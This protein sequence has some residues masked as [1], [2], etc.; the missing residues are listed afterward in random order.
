MLGAS[1]G[2]VFVPCAGPGAGAISVVAATN[3]VGL[4]A[5]LLTIAYAVGAAVPM[6]LI[7]LGGQRPRSAC[8]RTHRGCE[9]PRAS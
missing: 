4:R 7:A 1:L 6:L 5:I 9:S 3:H 8:A 2:L